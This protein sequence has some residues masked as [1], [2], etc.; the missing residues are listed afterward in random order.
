MFLS[1]VFKLFFALAHMLEMCKYAM[2]RRLG[3][4]HPSAMRWHNDCILA[5][6][7][8]DC[9]HMIVLMHVVLKAKLFQNNFFHLLAT[10]QFIFAVVEIVLRSCYSV[11]GGI[12]IRRNTTVEKLFMKGERPA[13]KMLHKQKHTCNETLIMQ[14]S[15]CSFC[16]ITW[17]N[18]VWMFM[19]Y[20]VSNTLFQLL[21]VKIIH[22]ASSKI[23]T[24]FILTG[25][26]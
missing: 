18:G 6:S 14:N 1:F 12:R 8:N 10:C 3:K 15:P 9:K 24:S 5:G 16:I 23:I 22:T 17:L 13:F 20:Y 25:F 19:H 7:S 4:V 2:W 26:Q 21:N 11:K